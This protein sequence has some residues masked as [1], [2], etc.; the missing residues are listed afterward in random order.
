MASKRQLRYLARDE[1]RAHGTPVDRY[2]GFD[3]EDDDND[4]PA[5]LCGGCGMRRAVVGATLCS[6]CG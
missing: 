6:T 3:G 5:D 2:A 1:A 4:A